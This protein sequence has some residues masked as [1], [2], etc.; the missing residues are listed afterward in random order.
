LEIQKTNVEKSQ[1]RNQ[2]HVLIA[3]LEVSLETVRRF[4]LYR[5]NRADFWYAASFGLVKMIKIIL[6]KIR[7]QELSS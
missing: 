5:P 1:I 7:N 4:P 6:I 2:E 3:S